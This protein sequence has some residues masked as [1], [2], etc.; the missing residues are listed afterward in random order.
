MLMFCNLVFKT[1]FKHLTPKHCALGLQQKISDERVH[2]Y[3]S[4]W[5][6][7]FGKKIICTIKMGGVKLNLLNLIPLVEAHLHIG[8]PNLKPI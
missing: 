3:S 7:A 2:I 1:T 6:L 4:I 8:D 5:N